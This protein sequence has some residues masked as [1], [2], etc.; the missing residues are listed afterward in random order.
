MY[1]IKTI[2]DRDPIFLKTAYKHDNLIDLQNDERFIKTNEKFIRY[3]AGVWELYRMGKDR[4]RRIVGR[5]DKLTRAVF[6]AHM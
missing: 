2:T 4:Q 6:H 5:Y 1:P 3:S